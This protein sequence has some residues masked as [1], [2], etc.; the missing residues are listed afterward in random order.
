VIVLNSNCG[1]IGGCGAGSTEEKWLR[2]DLAAS[3]ADCTVA[4]WHHPRFSS[5]TTHSGD[6]TLAPFWKALYDS[7][8]DVVINGHEHNYKRFAPQRS[9]GTPDAA[10]GVRQFTAG[11]GGQ[12]HYPFGPAI[13]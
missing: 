6:A 10:F 8:A 11:T 5:G 1:S 3:A 9:D 12:S 2:A 13:P 7:G 4:I